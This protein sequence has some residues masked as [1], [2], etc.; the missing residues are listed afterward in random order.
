MRCCATAR[1]RALP[2]WLGLFAGD[3]AGNQRGRLL[4]RHTLLWWI[5]QRADSMF[6]R[7]LLVTGLL[8]AVTR[9]SAPG[10]EWWQ[11]HR[12]GQ[13]ELAAWLL[14]AN[15]ILGVASVDAGFALARQLL[16]IGAP[17]G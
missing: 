11:L 8:R 6:W 15:V 4:A 2:G 10:L 3:D 14:A 17:A 16:R 7:S 9:F 1:T 5:E 13:S 12:A